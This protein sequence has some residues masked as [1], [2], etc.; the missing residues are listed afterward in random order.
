[1]RDAEKCWSLELL[2]HSPLEA[3]C[4]KFYHSANS[5][6]ETDFSGIPINK[7]AMFSHNRCVKVGEALVY[8][9]EGISVLRIPQNLKQR[10]DATM[11]FIR[12]EEITLN[13]FVYYIAPSTAFSR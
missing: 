10:A 1:M 12:P 9:H 7:K 5:D 2:T 13:N 6:F 3:F 11:A 8:S 4:P